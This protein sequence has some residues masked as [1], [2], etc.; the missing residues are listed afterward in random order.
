M[1]KPEA[2]ADP[3]PEWT[4]ERLVPGGDGFL[5]LPGGRAAFVAGALPGDRVEP[6]GLEVHRDYVKSR[7]FHLLAAG[8]DRIEPACPVAA[9]CGGCDW[10]HLE[11][12][13][14]LRAKSGLL[15]EALHRTGGFHELPPIDVVAAGPE[16]GYRSR[17]RVHVDEAGR[18]G[19]FAR[20][21]HTLVEIPGCIVCEPAVENALSVVRD[22]AGRFPG[23]LAAF[24]EIEIRAAPAGPPVALR[25]FPRRR[26]RAQ[27]PREL[28]RELREHFALSIEGQ[29]EDHPDQR[30]PLPGAV[31]LSAPPAAFTQVNWTA[32]LALVDYVVQNAAAR[33]LRTFC[34]LYCGA[35]NFTLP[36]AK[37]GLDGTG[38]DRVGA[39]LGA[40]ER[41]AREQGLKLEFI[42]GVVPVVLRQLLE[43]ARRFDLVLLDPP[44]TGAREALAGVV[45][46]A[47]RSIA[48]CSCDPVTL[49]RDLREL[50]ARGYMLETVRGF[51]LFPQTHHVEAVAWMQSR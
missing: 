6:L 17:L 51:D 8:P 41:A 11:R 24:A 36:L 48:I 10:M 38:V 1:N 31:E 49:A 32:N 28:V 18:I 27:S 40:G 7:R 5:R 13:A 26:G 14:Q 47:P 16:L 43:S 30:Y 4:I 46:L 45:E 50:S 12:G 19:L 33:E 22:V 23:R 29:G 20:G 35:G 39:A 34:D 9:R 37:A 2:L 44:R 42:S 15:R 25:L 3:S 21:S